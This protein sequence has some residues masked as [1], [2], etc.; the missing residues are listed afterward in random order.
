M[1]DSTRPPIHDA[2]Y[3]GGKLHQGEGTCKQPAGWGTPHAGVGR[4][5]LHGGCAPSS[6][7]AGA[8]ALVEK[9]AYELFG[10]LVEE[11]EPV[12]NPLTA[13][14]ELAA[15]VLTW[16]RVLRKL[17]DEVTRVGYSHERIGEQIDARVQVYE[18][19]LDRAN[20]VLGTFARLRI[21]E[22]LAA[23]SQ[24]Q[25][26]IIIEAL[27]AALNAA[28]VRDT[29]ARNSARRAAAAHLRVVNPGA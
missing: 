28:G 24:Q 23:I 5:K 11:A 12:E 14:A 26:D 25:T 27:D 4:C 9:Q 3:C 22:R 20:A 7:K 10:Q 15:E 6:V 29:G 18:R 16:K 21:D 17:L 13:F 1:K 8:A 2:R 19:A